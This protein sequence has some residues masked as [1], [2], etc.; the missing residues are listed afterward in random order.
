MTPAIRIWLFRGLLGVAIL[1]CLVSY[2]V[3]GVLLSARVTVAIPAWIEL[4][5]SNLLALLIAVVSVDM[6]RAIPRQ[7]RL[8]RMTLCLTAVIA[9][10]LAIFVKNAAAPYVMALCGVAAIVV[11]SLALRRE[12]PLRVYHALSWYGVTWVLGFL[13]ALYGSKLSSPWG[14]WLTIGIELSAFFTAVAFFAAWCT[15]IRKV[16]LTSA[17]MAGLASLEFALLVATAGHSATG[18]ILAATGLTLSLPLFVYTL[19]VFFVVATV[20]TLLESDGQSSRGVAALLLVLSG[21]SFVNSNVVL[22]S[23]LSLEL[24]VISYPVR[25]HSLWHDWRE[26]LARKWRSDKLLDQQLTRV[27]GGT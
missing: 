21:F 20:L 7:H 6:T 19:G 23:V 2:I 15:P 13:G 27:E 3:P 5:L 1:Q 8:T 25:S 10:S 26:V 11:S 14:D 24:L 4:F 22:L 18:S 17:I 12:I 16:R 9:P